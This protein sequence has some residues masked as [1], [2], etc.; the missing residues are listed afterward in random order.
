[1]LASTK[2]LPPEAAR[3]TFWPPGFTIFR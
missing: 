3:R 1:V 2:L